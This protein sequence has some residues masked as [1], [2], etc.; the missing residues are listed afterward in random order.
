MTDVSPTNADLAQHLEKNEE[1]QD[2]QGDILVRLT[3]LMEVLAN[4]VTA[5]ETDNRT[6]QTALVDIGKALVRYEERD[7]S[8][9]RWVGFVISGGV[10]LAVGVAMFLV[11]YY[12]QH[13]K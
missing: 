11:G 4:R 3:T 5:I 12:I 10:A 2:K 8:T 1:R 9:Q 13:P 6:T 7:T